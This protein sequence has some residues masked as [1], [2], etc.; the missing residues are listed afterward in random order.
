MKRPHSLTYSKGHRPSQAALVSPPR[1]GAYPYGDRVFVQHQPQRDPRYD[2]RA[3]YM[4]EQAEGPDLKRRRFESGY[5]PSRE[6]FREVPT[7][8]PYSPRDAGSHPPP[9]HDMHQ[10]RPSMVPGP[11]PRFAYPQAPPQ[12]PKLQQIRPPPPQHKRNPSLTLPPLSTPAT[13]TPSSSLSAVSGLEAMIMSIPVLNKVKILSQISPHLVSPSVASPQP[14][15]RGA[16][17]AVEGLDPDSV[18]DMTNTLAEQLGKDDKFAVKVFNGPDPFANLRTEGK[19]GRKELAIA[20]C[21]NVIGEWHKISEEMKRYITTR[22]VTEIEDDNATTSTFAREK[23]SSVVMSDVNESARD[24]A[25]Q[26]TPNRDHRP[27]K[28]DLQPPEKTT[29]TE[30]DT[31]PPT[32]GKS[33]ISPKTIIANKTA[34]LSITTPPPRKDSVRNPW[35]RGAGDWDNPDSPPYTRI[36]NMKHMMRSSPGRQTET[37]ASGDN[38]AE[39]GDVITVAVAGEK[40]KQK[41]KEAHVHF[42]PSTSSTPNMGKAS[43]PSPRRPSIAPARRMSDPNALIPIALVP[44]YQLSTVDASAIAMPIVDSYSP[45]AHWQW[46]ATLWRGCVGPDV[47]VV[48]KH[49]GGIGAETGS[50]AGLTSADGSPGKIPQGAMLAGSVP[51]SRTESIAAASGNAAATPTTATPTNAPGVE[52]RLTECRAVVVRTN[53]LRL[54]GGRA[55]S[56]GDG[57]GSREG[58]VGGTMAEEKRRREEV[59]FWEKAKRRVGFEVAEFVRR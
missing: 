25:R 27:A 12:P 44:H 56:I 18:W 53:V 58:S 40:E 11:P 32:S 35:S 2:P 42:S 6:V 21:L 52:V 30:A 8:Y 9:H 54:N 5:A 24:D 45:L 34:D 14:E 10:Q 47:S 23:R 37:N 20:D 26:K 28:L 48:I 36:P 39:M 22:P 55:G 50:L 13:Q 38:D 4:S 29:A 46:L 59:D 16:I 49:T 17:I 41:D 1:S 19:A 43:I 3:R 31:E 51:R 15:V 33:N 7:A 57:R